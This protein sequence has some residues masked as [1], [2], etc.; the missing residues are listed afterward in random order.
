MQWLFLVLAGLAEVAFAYCLGKA[1][2]TAGPESVGWYVAFTSFAALSFYLLNSS[3]V[4][5][6]LGTAYA[7]WTGIGAVG[8]AI[9]GVVAFGD[10]LTGPRL[11]FL[12][13]LIGSVLGLKAVSH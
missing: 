6:P 10:P 5:V 9:L 8:T 4:Y 1:K 2:L 12:V 13:T 7:V 11:F 3:L